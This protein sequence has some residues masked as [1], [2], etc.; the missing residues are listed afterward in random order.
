MMGGAIA[1]NLVGAGTPVSGYDPS[2]Q[3]SARAAANGVFVR[4]SAE[5]VGAESTIVFTSLPSSSAVLQVVESLCA[6]LPRRGSIIV[7]TSTIDLGEKLAIAQRAA[8]AG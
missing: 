2:E 4:N 5:E 6:S 7:E 1:R 8:T 3:A